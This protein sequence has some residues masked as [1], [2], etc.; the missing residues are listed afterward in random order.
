MA[1]NPDLKPNFQLAVIRGT[2]DK[3]KF[4]F[5]AHINYTFT[6]KDIEFAN[7]TL[8]SKGITLVSITCDQGPSNIKVA[9]HYNIS[10]D[11][12]KIP[13]P[14]EE[15]RFMFYL[16]DFPHLFKTTRNHCLGINSYMNFN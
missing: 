11:N 3:W 7:Q 1:I 8:D 4:P 16:W 2:A 6:P 13:H 9:N 10:M 14:T 5:F 15:G 12:Q